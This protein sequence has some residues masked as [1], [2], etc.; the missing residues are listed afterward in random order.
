MKLKMTL[1]IFYAIYII[2]ISTSAR[3]NIISV[4]KYKN[5]AISHRIDIT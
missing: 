5:F 2:L 1:K 3:L 4:T